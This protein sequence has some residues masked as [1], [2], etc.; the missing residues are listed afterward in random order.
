MRFTNL[1]FFEFTVPRG[2]LTPFVPFLTCNTNMGIWRNVSICIQCVCKLV[3]IAN[4]QISLFNYSQPPWFVSN[5]RVSKS[6]G[7]GRKSQ[8]IMDIC[9]RNITD[10]SCHV[11]LQCTRAKYSILSRGLT[12]LYSNLGI[13]N[14]LS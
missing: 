11:L 12:Q 6:Q 1:R 13:G 8:L 9:L 4:R 5:E 10:N 7:I 2:L 14:G 3:S